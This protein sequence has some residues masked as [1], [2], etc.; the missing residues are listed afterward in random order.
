MARSPDL[1]RED[2]TL[3]DRDEPEPSAR[4]TRRAPLPGE[5]DA[6]R[7]VPVSNV[8]G[9]APSPGGDSGGDL[10]GAEDD[11]ANLSEPEP[12][13]APELDGFTVREEELREEPGPDE[14]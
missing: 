4:P 1:D 3:P 13:A 7:V 11:L 6:E 8:G 10:P 9:A 14:E 12:A 5:S 2:V